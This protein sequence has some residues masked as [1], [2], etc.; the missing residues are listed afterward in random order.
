MKKVKQIL[1]IICIVI[2]LGLYIATFIL[3]LTD[4]SATMF[5]FKG[6]VACTI[7]IPVVAYLYL[8]LHKYAMTRSGRRDCY[9]HVSSDDDSE[10][11][12]DTQQKP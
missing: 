2:L 12:A 5:M 9:S 7:F 4:N 10:A 6:C 11:S 1:A 3:A 8:C